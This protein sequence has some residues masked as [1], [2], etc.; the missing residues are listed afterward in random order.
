[1]CLISDDGG[2][3]AIDGVLASLAL[4]APSRERCSLRSLSVTT[5][6]AFCAQGR[7]LLT[8]FSSPPLYI[9]HIIAVHP[10]YPTL[11]NA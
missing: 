4:F 5:L 3:E 6:A 11:F 10:T 8:P 9:S 2:V 1:M 7:H